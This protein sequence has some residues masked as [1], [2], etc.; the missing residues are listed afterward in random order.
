MAGIQAEKKKHSPTSF[1]LYHGAFNGKVLGGG[2]TDAAGG[3]VERFQGWS[4]YNGMHLNETR[5]S[6]SF[7]REDTF[8]YGDTM[9]FQDGN[10]LHNKDADKTRSSVTAGYGSNGSTRTGLRNST[11]ASSSPEYVTSDLKSDRPI[12]SSGS[13]VPPLAGGSPSGGRSSGNSASNVNIAHRDDNPSS[14][15]PGPALHGRSSST[16][17]S[18]RKEHHSTHRRQMSDVGSG[19]VDDGLCN[20]DPRRNVSGEISSSGSSTGGSTPRI[21]SDSSPY[22]SRSDSG[23][24]SSKNGSSGSTSSSSGGS[25][26]VL[27]LKVGSSPVVDSPSPRASTSSSGG[28]SR[29]S[30]LA[31]SPT[32]GRTSSVGNLFGTTTGSNMTG[33]GGGTSAC[34]TASTISAQSRSSSCNLARGGSTNGGGLSTTGALME[35][36]ITG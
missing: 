10:G 22:W 13:G 9:S 18:F 1:D 5:I 3:K 2:G 20:G 6:S 11:Y 30:S 31:G 15:S 25:P 36:N 34:E 28:S 19:S 29:G 17:D 16:D 7:S 27:S 35:N 12:R 26:S 21:G 32:V 8:T 23:R 14:T 4:R 33:V 24:F